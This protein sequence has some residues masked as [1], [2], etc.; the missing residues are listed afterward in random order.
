MA[1]AA[2]SQLDQFDQRAYIANVNQT[3]ANDLSFKQLSITT[4]IISGPAKAAIVVDR[5]QLDIPVET[6]DLLIDGS[7]SLT[8]GLSLSDSLPTANLVRS[9]ILWTAKFGV[10]KAAAALSSQ[11][12]NLRPVYD[13]GEIGGL[14]LPID[15]VFG[16]IT[17][18]SLASAAGC[19]INMWYH[20]IE[21]TKENYWELLEMRQVLGT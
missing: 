5:I 4:G 2:K 7:D 13:F 15:R 3:A 11:L 16:M 18:E 20:V 9:E 12:C 1:S 6:F 8:I 10:Q 17:S 19:S 14:L 21:L